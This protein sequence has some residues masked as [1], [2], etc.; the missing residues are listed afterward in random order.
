VHLPA[1]LDTADAIRTELQRP[2]LVTVVSAHAGYFPG[3]RRLGICGK[4]NRPVLLAD[5]VDCLGAVSM[6]LIDTCF[7]ADLAIELRDHAQ[8]GSLLAGLNTVPGA[9]QETRGRDSVTALGAVI[10]EV[11]YPSVAD[12]SPHTIRRAVESVNAQITARNLTERKRGVTNPDAT[13][14]LIDMHEC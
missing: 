1:D 9:S 10:R 7:A 8:P 12:L 5:S 13:R 4:D 3:G 6:V 14:P 11:C 2:C